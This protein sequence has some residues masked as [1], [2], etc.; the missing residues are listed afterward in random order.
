MM[1]LC[2]RINFY[3]RTGQTWFENHTF[4][5]TVFS[6]YCQVVKFIIQQQT[7]T[8]SDVMFC[9]SVVY[10]TFFSINIKYN[11]KN[12]KYFYIFEF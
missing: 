12:I 10:I 5:S 3:G 7:E 4:F 11:N 8:K 9:F 1:F 2:I 6:T